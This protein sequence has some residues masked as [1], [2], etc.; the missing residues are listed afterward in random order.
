MIDVIV[1]DDVEIFR[2]G[3]AKILEVA[4]D[5]RIVGEPQSAEQLLSALSASAP[6]VLI[7]STSFLPVI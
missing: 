6:H 5:V 3:M 1:A 7:L 2:L 4:G